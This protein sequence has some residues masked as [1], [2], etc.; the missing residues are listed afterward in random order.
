[1]PWAILRGREPS[2][3]QKLNFNSG[4]RNEAAQLELDRIQIALDRVA[5]SLQA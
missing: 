3:E 2:R 5:E 1:M 4:D